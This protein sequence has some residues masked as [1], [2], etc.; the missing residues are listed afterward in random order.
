[1]AEF[2]AEGRKAPAIA[3]KDQDGVLHRLSQYKDS[4]VV[5]YFYPKDDTSGCTTQACGF[6]DAWPEFEKLDAVVLGVSPDD[7]KSHRRF[8]DKHELPFTL[9]ADPKQD[10]GT[11][12]V[13]D[14]YGVWREKNMYGRKYM[15]VART[16]YLIA[17]GGRIIRRFDKVKPKGHAEEV[18]AAIEE[19]NG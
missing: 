7:E 9:L 8:A 12:V 2:V 19:A 17:P 15:G 10:D 1:M 14:K 4:F 18:L 6:R 16:T 3:L 11:P 5:L 13:C